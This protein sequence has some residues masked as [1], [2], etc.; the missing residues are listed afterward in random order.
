MSDFEGASVRTCDIAARLT[1]VGGEVEAVESD[2]QRG[3]V[4]SHRGRCFLC[5]RLGFGSLGFLEG[6][7]EELEIG[8]A[9][10]RRGGLAECGVDTAD[11][12]PGDYHLAPTQG[13]HVEAQC[14]PSYPEH[15]ASLAVIEFH[16]AE[17][18]SAA[19]QTDADVSHTDVGLQLLF[20]RGYEALHQA[21]LN[22]LRVQ[23]YRSGRHQNDDDSR[24]Y[25]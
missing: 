23:Q 17:H 16:V 5:W 4:E 18:H 19:E 3:N 6:I 25:A 12:G 22:S 14:Q 10:C 1:V 21:V 15:A 2:V 8:G 11:L 20:Q 7:K 24:E 13:F 9:V